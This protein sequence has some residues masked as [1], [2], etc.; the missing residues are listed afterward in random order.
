MQSSDCYGVGP[1]DFATI[2][3]VA[4]AWNASP[5]IDGTGQ[6][7]A[8]VGETDINP[9]DVT[10]FRNFFGLPAYGQSGGPKLN[11]IHDGPAPG[12]LSDGEESEADLDVEWSGAVAKGASVDFVVSES[13]ETTAGV[14]SLGTLHC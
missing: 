10:D 8:I 7:I 4:P 9:Q 3:N 14:Q 1:Y 11:I 13:T 5:A 2:Y 12:I 6:T